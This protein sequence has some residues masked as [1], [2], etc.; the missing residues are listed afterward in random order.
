MLAF[1]LYSPLLLLALVLAVPIVG[2][3]V[4][5][6]PIYG[7]ML[8]WLGG[9]LRQTG[10]AERGFL[11]AVAASIVWISISAP[12]P[13]AILIQAADRGAQ[14]M[15]M[16]VALGLLRDAARNSG[17][18]RD[19]GVWLI[20]QKP[21]W[22]FLAIAVGGHGFGVA[23]NMGAIL[24]L[25]TLIKRS[26]T[27]EAAGGDPRVVA[28]REERMNAALMQGFFTMLLWS[29]MSI[30][31]AFS[32]ALVPGV[33]WFDIGLPALALTALFLAIAW[34]LDRIKFP[35]GR[36]IAPPRVE[37][38]P[39]VAIALPMAGLI[40]A[41]IALV[42][43]VKAFLHYGMIDAITAVAAVFGLG[44]LHAGHR[45]QGQRPFAAMRRHLRRHAV[46]VMP[47]MR[48]ETIVL[49]SASF[50]GVALAFLTRQWGASDLLDALNAPGW[51]LAAGIVLFVVAGGQVG[52]VALVTTAIAGGAVLGMGASPLSPVALALSLQIGWAL[53]A[54]LS[55]Y[56]GGSMLL[57]RIAEVSPVVTR[58]WNLPWATLCFG[59]YT[60]LAYLFY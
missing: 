50:L 59:F 1:V 27:L 19:C 31:V 46:E 4:L 25:G 29:P 13:G 18:V 44:W 26:N 33:T 24:L 23:L 7:A 43:G 15:G 21:A 12:V 58:R 37:A 57:A 42:L 52:V 48:A 32:L 40:L 14:F 3:D 17:I 28:V 20:A 49:A 30:S 55:A 10:R 22:R 35:P 47:E 51:L 9:V 16:M 34:L 8:I 38:P 11:A 36:R 39:P 53:S 56:S 41:L 54:A 60:V 6:W 5:R 45:G 2:P